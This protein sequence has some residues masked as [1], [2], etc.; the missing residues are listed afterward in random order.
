MRLWF[1]EKVTILVYIVYITKY[2][3]KTFFLIISYIFEFILY[4]N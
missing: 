3:L 4:Y 2:D 1:L